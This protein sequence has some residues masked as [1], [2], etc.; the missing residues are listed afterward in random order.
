M[1]TIPLCRSAVVFAGFLW[2]ATIA[3]AGADQTQTSTKPDAGTPPQ[4]EVQ[5]TQNRPKKKP[6]KS[7]AWHHFGESASAS[8]AGQSRPGVWHRFGL[9]H[10]TPEVDPD[11]TAPRQDF[12]ADRLADLERQMWAL[13]NRDRRRDW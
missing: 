6:D 5:A 8:V 9:N 4:A 12:G 13:V 1:K 10:G 7:G 3:C 2:A 11:E